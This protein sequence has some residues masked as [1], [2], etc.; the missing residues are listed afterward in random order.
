MFRAIPLGYPDPLRMYGLSKMSTEY[1]LLLDTD[2][3]PNVK[4]IK[5]LKQYNE[6]DIYF[7]KRYKSRLKIMTNQVRLFRRNKVLFRGIIHEFPEIPGS[8]SSLP[9]DE[10][11]IHLAMDKSDVPTPDYS[12]Y[13]II[14]LFQDIHIYLIIR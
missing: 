8:I 14:E 4:L 1:V 9:N 5:N 12:R 7:I 6:Y 3:I 2:E 13:L 10:Y 11:I